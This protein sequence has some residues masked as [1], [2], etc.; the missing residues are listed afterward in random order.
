MDLGS[1]KKLFITTSTDKYFF[2]REV[3]QKIKKKCGYTRPS[4][5]K[6]CRLPLFRL[7]ISALSQGFVAY[8]HFVVLRC[9][10]PRN[11]AY[12]VETITLG[13]H[14]R[15]TRLDRELTQN[16]VATMIGVATDTITNWELNRNSPRKSYY[17]AIY[18]FL[19]KVPL[20]H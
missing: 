4:I 1:L 6:G 20:K 19:G 15:K 16:Q 8:L 18:D 12:P 11:P 17:S 14:I 3:H 10:R 5:I 7:L 13:D 9:K 2:N